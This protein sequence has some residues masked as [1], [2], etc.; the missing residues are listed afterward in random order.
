MSKVITLESSKS[1]LNSSD[2]VNKLNVTASS[3]R[4]YTSHF[5]RLGYSFTK[6]NGRV[7]YSPYDVELFQKM[8]HLHENEFGT[9]TECIKNVLNVQEEFINTENAENIHNNH[10][11]QPKQLKHTH[12]SINTENEIARIKQELE[13]LRKYVDESIKK[14]DELLLQTLREVIETKQQ[15]QKKKRWWQ[16]WK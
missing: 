6:K 15:K 10:N 3:L 1:Y 13:E 14:R 4:T 5:R 12:T 8:I 16:F 11:K 2:V 9:I 7:L